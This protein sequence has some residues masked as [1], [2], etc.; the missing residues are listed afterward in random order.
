M[1]HCAIGA[2]I[3]QARIALTDGMRVLQNYSK[4][5]VCVYRKENDIVISRE[6]LL[7]IR[8]AI[9]DFGKELGELVRQDY[10][11]NATLRICEL[12]D[13][14]V[15]EPS[16][17]ATRP[18]EVT[19][20]EFLTVMRYVSMPDKDLTHPVRYAWTH[21]LLADLGLYVKGG[22]NDE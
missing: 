4:I 7:E 16:A 12:L 5:W 19:Q 9:Q 10:V 8:C 11:D 6:K 20:N 14:E 3:Q 21:D 13:P 18:V 2:S 1:Q 17:E 22:D 15:H